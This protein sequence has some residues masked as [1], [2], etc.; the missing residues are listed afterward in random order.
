M[1][2][3]PFIIGSKI[4]LRAPE[5]GDKEIIAS[6]E[7]HPSPRETLFYALP[8]SLSGMDEKLKSWI[9]DPHTVVFTICNKK[10]AKIILN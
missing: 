10:L 1:M 6:S 8:R 4:Y 9:E 7:N 3:N 2:Q 5:E